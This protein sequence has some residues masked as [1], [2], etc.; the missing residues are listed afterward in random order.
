MCPVNL[1]CGASNIAA[2]ALIISHADFLGAHLVV[3]L[4]FSILV[5]LT[6]A[7]LIPKNSPPL[8]LSSLV[9]E[10]YKD[11]TKTFSSK[12]LEAA[13]HLWAVLVNG[14]QMSGCT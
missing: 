4:N 13:S 5:L 1:L 9:I 14:Y 6:F 11:W 7:L 2:L 12:H 8:T 3:S 10:H